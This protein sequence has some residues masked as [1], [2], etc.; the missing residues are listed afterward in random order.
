MRH[1]DGINNRT[2]LTAGI[3]VIATVAIG[4]VLHQGARILAPFAM[5]VFVWLVM[6][7]FARAIR[8][9]F[10]NL[11][12]W[13]AYLFAVIIVVM[14][15]VIFIGVIRGAVEEFVSKSADYER[16]IN[17]II[18]Q[19]YTQLN[20]LAPA[21][22]AAAAGPVAAPGEAI[23]AVP[24]PNPEAAMSA[25]PPTVA[26]LLSSNATS[27]AQI[28][29]NV[30]SS[31]VGDMVLVFIYVAFLIVSAGA[32]SKQLDEIFK[33]PKDRTRARL[34]GQEIRRTMEQYLWVQTALSIVSTLLTYVTLLIIGLDNALFWAFVIFV[35][36]FIPTVGS[37]IATILPTLFAVVQPLSAWPDWMPDD[38]LLCAVIV[39]LGVSVWQFLIGNFVAPRMQADSLNLSPLV[40]LLSLAVWGALWGPA[41]MFLSA[42]L[43][44]MVMIVLG[45]V[46]GA[47]WIAV[48]LS[49]NGNPG[50]YAVKE[51]DEGEGA[52]SG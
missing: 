36:N 16:H 45:Q 49:A 9:P 41:G 1:S 40:V 52:T 37:I 34:I 29:G 33:R 27:I 30:A 23:P 17:D 25:Q 39:F 18:E 31:L 11:P 43:T 48:L 13:L 12:G 14:S 47:R 26:Q 24:I 8:R 51:E 19:V 50:D 46:P 22:A 42:P 3:W 21:D 44:V 20:L 38:S 15:I 10:P 32:F 4:M 35:L 5:A 6:E 7:G 28:A 2:W